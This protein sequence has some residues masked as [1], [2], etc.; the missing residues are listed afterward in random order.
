M[1]IP[2]REWC[3]SIV[4]ARRTPRKSTCHPELPVLCNSCLST[5]LR[6]IYGHSATC[7]GHVHTQTPPEAYSH[8]SKTRTTFRT[9]ASGSISRRNRRANP[10][11]IPLLV[12]VIAQALRRREELRI[13]LA[14]G[15]A[16]A[17]AALLCEERGRPW[18]IGRDSRHRRLSRSIDRGRRHRR[19]ARS[20]RCRSRDCRLPHPARGQ[21]THCPSEITL[22]YHKATRKTGVG[23]EWSSAAARC[24]FPSHL[25]PH[26]PVSP[27]QPA[28]HPN[29]PSQCPNLTLSPSRHA[30]HPDPPP[31]SP[32][33]SHSPALVRRGW[34]AS[35]LL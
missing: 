27:T 35:S 32:P 34:H 16:A 28:S 26:C 21:Q 10:C 7:H 18:H 22:L 14:A 1:P 12:I 23:D 25:P 20:M 8:Q 17:A 6:G 11:C 19:L 13:R 24:H 3:D 5:L 2:C 33:L 4:K 15:A 9:P 30:T 29:A 31:H